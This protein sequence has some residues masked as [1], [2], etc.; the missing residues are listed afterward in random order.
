MKY[1]QVVLPV[2]LFIAIVYVICIG[3]YAILPEETIAFGSYLF[4][5]VKMEASKVTL[6][7]FVIGLIEAVILSVVGSALFVWIYNKF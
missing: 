7:G 4:H 5:G 6:T 3:F 1:K 2:T